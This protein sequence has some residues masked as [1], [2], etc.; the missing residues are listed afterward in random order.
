MKLEIGA[1][2]KPTPGYIHLDE[3]DLPDIEIIDDARIL[4]KIENESCDEILAK[5]VLEHFSHRDTL[6]ILKIWYSKIKPG[7]KIHIE[8]PDLKLFCTLWVNGYIREPWA[9]VSIYGGQDYDGNFHK[10]GFSVEYLTYLLNQVGFKDI[11]NLMKDIP[12]TNYE[13]KLEA[14]K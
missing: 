7:G 14:I 12:N 9:F 13:I 4:S 1:G 10:A 3:R 8:V 2:N 11:T 5:Q 6:N